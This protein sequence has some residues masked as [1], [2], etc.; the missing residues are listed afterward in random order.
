MQPVS[1]CQYCMTSIPLGPRYNTG[2]YE[3]LR[4][5]RAVWGTYLLPVDTPP[6]TEQHLLRHHVTPK[7]F[8]ICS[9]DITSF[10]SLETG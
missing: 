5:E 9:A 4:L 2:S 1:R 6:H 3:D 10:P 7:L 8:L